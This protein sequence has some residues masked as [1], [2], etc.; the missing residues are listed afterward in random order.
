MTREEIT[1]RLE[2]TKQHFIKASG[3]KYVYVYF[4]MVV[5][6]SFSLSLP[7]P[8]FLLSPKEKHRLLQLGPLRTDSSSDLISANSYM[9]IYKR[10]VLKPEP[11][12]DKNIR[13]STRHDTL[14]IKCVWQQQGAGWCQGTP[15]TDSLRRCAPSI[16]R[17]KQLAPILHQQPWHSP[18]CV[19]A[20]WRHHSIYMVV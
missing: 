12:Q 10:N 7:Y 20:C 1:D 19:K 2:I 17:L 4:E 9:L 18:H 5:Y 11:K 3:P 6:F 16:Q 14:H 8:L 15:A 13:S